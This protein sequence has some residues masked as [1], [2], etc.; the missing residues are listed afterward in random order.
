MSTLHL[1]FYDNQ[2]KTSGKFWDI[3]LTD[4]EIHTIYG[5][6]GSKGREFIIPFDDSKIEKHLQKLIHSKLQKGYVIESKKIPDFAKNIISSS[7]KDKKTVKKQLKKELEKVVEDKDCRTNR[8]RCIDLEKQKGKQLI[9]NPDSGRCISKPIDRNIGKKNK[10]NVVEDKDCRTNR[11]RCID[12]EKQKGKQLICNPDTGRCITKPSDR[13]TVKKPKEMVNTKKTIKTKVE[14]TPKVVFNKDAM[15]A[16]KFY[17]SNLDMEFKETGSNKKKHIVFNGDSGTRIGKKWTFTQR[18][19]L[20][21]NDPTGWL[22]SEKYDGV[23][24][25]WNGVNFMSRGHKIYH[26]PKWLKQLMPPGRA[27]DGELHSGI[28]NFQQVTGITRHLEPNE[29][30]WAQVTFQV[31]DIPEMELVKQPFSDRLE[32]LKEVVDETCRK[33]EHLDIPD[34]CPKKCPLQYTEQIVVKNMSHAYQLYKEA[35]LKGAEGVMLRPPDSIYEFKRSKHLLKWKPVLDA[36]GKVIGYNEGANRLT[37]KLGTFKVMLINDKTK[38]LE[39]DK[40]FNL[41]GRLTDV[42]RTKYKFSKGTI[43]SEPKKGGEYPLIGD[44]ITFTFMEYTNDGIPRQ[45][46]FQRIRKEM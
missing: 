20:Y 32:I 11:Q 16:D 6:I 13:K 31:F 25:I 3:F 9:C 10:K 29:R 34:F 5:N 23:R 46:I 28:G 17:D 38:E 40:V 14:K 1:V 21:N 27:L 26:A 24:A 4:N 30:D 33:W 43:I 45:P 36:E 44:I 35:I 41:S 22:L 42:F 18:P 12:M 2:E 15:L 37:G 39:Q 19:T 8:Q 7:P